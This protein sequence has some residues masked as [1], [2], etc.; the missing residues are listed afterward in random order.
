MLGRGWKPKTSKWKSDSSLMVHK[1][2]ISEKG[3]SLICFSWRSLDCSSQASW[4]HRKPL[5]CLGSL[6]RCR[7]P[8]WLGSQEP[9]FTLR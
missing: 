1:V 2:N 6:S 3:I 8:V 4:E 9:T 7:F 5:H